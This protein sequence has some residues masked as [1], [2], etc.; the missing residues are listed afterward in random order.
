MRPPKAVFEAAES[1]SGRAHLPQHLSVAA[2]K[3]SLQ[4]PLGQHATQPCI[5][6]VVWGPHNVSHP[7]QV[8][9]GSLWQQ[10]D[11]TH[12]TY[13][14]SHAM[15]GISPCIQPLTTL[16]ESDTQVQL[17]THTTLQTLSTS[18]TLAFFAGQTSTATMALPPHLGAALNELPQ[19]QCE[20]VVRLGCA[21]GRE[22]GVLL[23]HVGQAR[24]PRLD[25]GVVQPL[26]L[27]EP[28]QVRACEWPQR[29]RT[30]QH[31]GG[32]TG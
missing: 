8:A 16:T 7:R 20:G 11:D 5:L 9:A 28:V 18:C 24:V 12:T 22:Q 1:P 15:Q 27:P 13:R 19:P 6:A 32:V 17:D 26:L 14:H 3:A 10:R 21:V 23:Q 30:C 2:L 25:T 4:E 31:S 29:C